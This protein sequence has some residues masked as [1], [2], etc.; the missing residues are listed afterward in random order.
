M[1]VTYKVKLRMKQAITILLVGLLPLFFTSCTYNGEQNARLDAQDQMLRD[2]E[3]RLA[4]LNRQV[5]ALTVSM[6]STVSSIE[7]FSSELGVLA[8]TQ[9][10]TTDQIETL[11]DLIVT[12]QNQVLFMQ[13]SIVNLQLQDGVV[14]YLDPCGA[15]SG[16]NEILLKTSSGKIVAFFESGG[17]RFLTI[18][19]QNTNYRTTDAD[20]CYFFIDSNNQLAGE[21][22]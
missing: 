3:A 10:S 16:Y 22:H 4:E 18:L 21:H 9:G 12:L 17:N 19:A 11:E 2:H 13:T 14:A 6:N 15:A 5:A 7:A 8:S 1:N 20:K